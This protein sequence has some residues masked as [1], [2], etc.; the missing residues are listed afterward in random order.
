MKLL[1]TISLMFISNAVFAV[2]NYVCKQQTVDS[3]LFDMSNMTEGVSQ[4]RKFPMD[5]IQLKIYEDDRIIHTIKY[6]H[7]KKFEDKYTLYEVDKN[8]YGDISH[9]YGISMD[10]YDRCG[11]EYEDK[12]KD[13]EF[14]KQHK[15]KPNPN[16][17]SDECKSKIKQPGITFETIVFNK[18]NK[19]FVKTFVFEGYDKYGDFKSGKNEQQ[20]STSVS[21]GSCRYE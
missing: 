3:P 18:T 15:M 1:I 5:T 13:D 16:L 8:E 19:R 6:S 4:N 11:I 9:F 20:T 12:R 7:G 14:A 2:E 21:Y 10:A 17:I